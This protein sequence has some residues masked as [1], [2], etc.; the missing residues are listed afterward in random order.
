M[1][2][3]PARRRP[4]RR[5]RPGRTMSQCSKALTTCIF[6]RTAN[7][8]PC[9]RDFLVLMA[10]FRHGLELFF[11][12][13]CYCN[14]GLGSCLRKFHFS[15]VFFLSH[16]HLESCRPKIVFPPTFPTPAW[17]ACNIDERGGKDDAGSEKEHRHIDYLCAGLGSQ[18]SA[19]WYA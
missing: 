13:R 4:P 12:F 3:S 15:P 6:Q 7:H 8:G 10:C 9:G 5:G 14:N 16:R 19:R 2:R 18:P 17:T 1:I 11:D